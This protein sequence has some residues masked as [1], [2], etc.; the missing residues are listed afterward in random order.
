MVKGKKVLAAAANAFGHTIPA[1]KLATEL[2]KLGNETKMLTFG[3]TFNDLMKHY[4]VVPK[5]FSGQQGLKGI[6]K[7]KSILN[8]LKPDI[9]ITDFVPDFWFALWGKKQQRSPFL[10]RFAKKDWQPKCRVSIMRPDTLIGYARINFL[11]PDVM[12][13]ENG[14][15]TRYANSVLRS[16]K[17][18]PAAD[19]RE[20][21]G[22][23]VIV[24]PSIPAMDPLPENVSNFYP[25][26]HFVYT[27]P[28][29]LP[30]E[31]PLSPDLEDW[32][33]TRRMEG[34]PIVLITLGTLW[35][36]S[37]YIYKLLAECFEDSQFAV[38]MVLPIKE[39]RDLLKP[40]NGPRFYATAMVNL[41]ALT[42]QVDVVIHHSGHATSQTVVLAGK[43]AIT[44]TS[45]QPDREDIAIRLEN[46]NCVRHLGNDFFK[47]GLQPKEI[48]HA[49]NQVLHDSTIRAGVAAMSQ[50]IQEYIEQKG[51]QDFV[52]AVSDRVN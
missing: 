17:M 8:D 23:E 46:L 2:Q 38:V 20:I 34:I 44:I 43:P 31:A 12:G 1:L 28:L 5:L 18:E 14:S 27:G 41:L 22:A 26:A 45:G 51:I 42:R 29:L 49:V 35:R 24:I 33:L 15:W 21:A 7:M 4:G 13:I 25:N 11:M 36:H 32:L 48:Q 52:K 47:N 10:A 3:D 16:M 37:N 19:G 40:K 9:T 6:L 30:I 50:G 39:D